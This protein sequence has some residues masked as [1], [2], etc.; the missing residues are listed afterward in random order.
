VTASVI[1]RKLSAYPRPNGLALALKIFLFWIDLQP[2]LASTHSS[3]AIPSLLI[4]TYIGGAGMALPS[5]ILAWTEPE[6]S[7]DD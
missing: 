6:L 3:I 1:L 7:L 4:L 2:W 5:A